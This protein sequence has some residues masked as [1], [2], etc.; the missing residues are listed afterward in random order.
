MKWISVKDKMPNDVFDMAGKDQ[1]KVLIC[2]QNKTVKSCLF[3]RYKDYDGVFIE[4]RFTR[5]DATHWMPLP[6]PPKED[7]I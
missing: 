5:S 6:E 4:W 7:A 2:T 3:A 1:I